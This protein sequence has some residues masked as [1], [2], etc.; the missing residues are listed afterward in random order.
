MADP[1]AHRYGGQWTDD[2]GDVDLS[3]PGLAEESPGA[4]SGS[5]LVR[6]RSG[7]LGPRPGWVPLTGA[8]SPGNAEP[9]GFAINE[10]TLKLAL[11][12]NTTIYEYDAAA[13][14]A[15]AGTTTGFDDEAAILAG[16]SQGPLIARRGTSG[17]RVAELDDWSTVIA[18]GEETEVERPE[19]LLS[20]KGLLMEYHDGRAYLAGNDGSGNIEPTLY[21]SPG[22]V[23]AS[24][25]ANLSIGRTNGT[26]PFYRIENLVS[27][28]QGLFIQV[29]TGVWLLQGN[30]ETGDL[31]EVSQDYTVAAIAGRGSVLYAVGI[32]GDVMAWNGSVFEVVA[33]QFQT[34]LVD[35]SIFYREP[36]IVVGADPNNVLIFSTSTLEGVMRYSGVWSRFAL[37]GSVSPLTG[38]A[39]T[40]TVSRLGVGLIRHAGQIL[41]SFESGD[42]VALT[43]EAF[44]A[45]SRMEIS[46][47]DGIYAAAMV[48]Q[49]EPPEPASANPTDL[50]S[51]DEDFGTAVAPTLTFPTRWA[52]PGKQFQVQR[53]VACIKRAGS[54]HSGDNELTLEMTTFNRQG[55][56]TVSAS[57]SYAWTDTADAQDVDFVVWDLPYTDVRPG[58]SYSLAV[59]NLVGC[60]LRHFE[61]LGEMQ[62]GWK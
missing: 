58:D 30:G 50:E 48:F 41:R 3:I 12:G 46:S 23:L 35:T 1:F 7:L 43:T 13:S 56:G 25:T 5:D 45:P 18:S 44:V 17:Y 61:V 34:T 31:R 11:D 60:A 29:G 19:A 28:E 49:E 22:D 9:V 6:Y 15:S 59:T 24:W 54:T 2:L 32:N 21:F 27:H 10:R 37:S 8:T 40:S 39:P 57:A 53:V 55:G 14:W 36:A 4:W 33:S 62:D 26:E 47:A 52:P 20:S 42:T 51:G 16:G 38:Q